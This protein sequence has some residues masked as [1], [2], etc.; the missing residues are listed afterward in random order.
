MAKY[1]ASIEELAPSLGSSPQADYILQY[2]KQL[3]TETVVVE[4]EYIDKDF[5]ID[6]AK[7][8]SRSH[9]SFE[10][11]TKRLH[12][13]SFVFAEAEFEH[14]LDIFKKN[15]GDNG[16]ADIESNGFISKLKENY[17]GF[18]ILK[19]ILDENGDKLFGRTLLRLLERCKNIYEKEKFLIKNNKV[20]LYGIPLN[21]STLPFQVQ[22]TAVAACA[23][24]ALWIANNKLNELFGT[25][26]LSPYEV[27]EI[28]TN[29]VEKTRSFPTEGLTI[30]QMLK[31]LRNI[32]LDYDIINIS[33]L[34]SVLKDATFSDKIKEKYGNLLNCVIPDAVKAFLDANIPLIVGVK[35][36]NLNKKGLINDQEFHAVVISG[37]RQNEKG[38]I[39][40]IYVHD[41]QIGP[42]SPIKSAGD[43]N[44]FL[45]WNCGWEKYYNISKVEVDFLI[46]PVYPKMRF[47]FSK[48][49]GL[50]MEERERFPAFVIDVHFT[51]VQ[52]YKKDFLSMPIKNKINLLKK[53]MPR[54]LWIVGIYTRNFLA[55]EEVYDA[56]SHYM[57]HMDTIDFYK[58]TYTGLC[59]NKSL[60]GGR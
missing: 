38:V 20:S 17:V 14:E 2:L 24:T 26:Q 40:E 11:F 51:D 50:V 23:T 46:I 55:Y 45:E 54:F 44:S 32:N 22:D 47:A 41:D 60:E 19:P 57:R 21:V 25:P 28:A 39:Q 36:Y 43:N 35:L 1:I 9:E 52:D 10:R 7:F 30:E 34:K 33:Y 13:F 18:I 3:G 5:I 27:T 42:Y 59:R 15:N 6:Y 12:F 37:Y 8:F 58:L 48:I 31:F 49:H 4:D 56:T 53:P 16:V 29:F